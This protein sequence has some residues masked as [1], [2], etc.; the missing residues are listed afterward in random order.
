MLLVDPF[1][2]AHGAD[3]RTTGLE[4]SD[5]LSHVGHRQQSFHTRSFVGKRGLDP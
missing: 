3:P 2:T 5:E 1:R 4:V